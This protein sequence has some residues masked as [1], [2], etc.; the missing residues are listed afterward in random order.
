MSGEIH[1]KL[2]ILV[3]S[4]RGW[5]ER[6]EDKNLSCLY[7]ELFFFS[8]L[9]LR[10]EPRALHALSQHSAIGLQIQ[11]LSNFSLLKQDLSKLS[12]PVLSFLCSPN[13][14]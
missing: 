14:P 1:S 7:L 8:C 2:I 4:G 10:I 12:K 11:P 3:R 13:K 9:V 5:V 6:A